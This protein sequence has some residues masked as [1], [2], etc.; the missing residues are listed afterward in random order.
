MTKKLF[1][2]DPYQTTCK[3]KVTAINGNKVKLDQTIFYAFSGGQ[4]SDEGS[5]NSI[6]V[7]E[8]RKEGDK[9]TIIDIEYTLEESP[10]FNVGDEVEVQINEERRRNLRN[11]HSAVHI[12]YYILIEKLG[13]LKICGSNVSPEKGRIDVK[14]EENISETLIPIEEYTN[15][16][17]AEDHKIVMEDDP[18]NPDQKWWTLDQWRMPCG[19][20]H[21]KST[22][23]I[24]KI[25]LKRKN[26]GS[27]KERIEVTLA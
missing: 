9:E 19:G 25:K 10:N 20:T 2:D 21:I 12:I 13:D 1:W 6:K 24:G 18:S 26:M 23:E 3:A 11:L 5:I 22:K 27:G 16:F 4:A 17:L 7:L 15:K 14:F 8:A